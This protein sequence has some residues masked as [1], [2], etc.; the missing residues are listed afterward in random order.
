MLAIVP[1]NAPPAGKRRLEGLLDAVQRTE[2]VRAMLDDVLR[3]CRQASLIRSVMLVTPDPTLACPGCEV[4]LDPGNGH[5][6][7]LRL[8]LR[9]PRAQPGA[10]I[11]MAD[12][13]LVQAETIDALADSPSSVAVCPARDGGTNALALRPTNVIEPAFGV[14]DGAAVVIERALAAG[15]EPAV[16]DDERLALDLDTAED[17][18]RIIEYGAGTASQ[19]LLTRLL[20]VS[21]PVH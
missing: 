8:A 9:D 19:E 18:A 4:L 17:A 12:C 6:S 10:V 14:P 11:V 3:A 13:P 5:A 20:P 21:T 2:L 15:I 1:V 16:L 7:A